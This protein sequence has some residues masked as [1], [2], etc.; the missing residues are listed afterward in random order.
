MDG[1]RQLP[2]KEKQK[3]RVSG[4]MRLTGALYDV[5][6]SAGTS[7]QILSNTGSGTDWVDASNFGDN[8]GNHIATTHLNMSDYDLNTVNE[9][10]F[11]DYDDN[12][13]GGRY[14]NIHFD[15]FLTT[16]FNYS[17]GIVLHVRE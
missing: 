11:R 15:V 14:V 4:N 10:S 9:L 1:S 13:G 8:L 17:G 3:L 7:G 16:I 6:N 2:V 12:P 5:N